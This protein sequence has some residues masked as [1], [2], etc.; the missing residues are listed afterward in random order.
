MKSFIFFF[1]LF[2]LIMLAIHLV[3]LGTSELFSLDRAEMLRLCY[4]GAVAVLLSRL[5]DEK[6]I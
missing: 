5:L 6:G 4:A 2:V 1:G 3:A